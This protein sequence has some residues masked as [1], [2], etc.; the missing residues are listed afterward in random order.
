VTT[1]N[2]PTLSS[3]VD[4]E[5]RRAFLAIKA[6]ADNL[7]LQ[8]TTG[9]GTSAGATQTGITQ[10]SLLAGLGA[11]GSLTPFLDATVPPALVN[12]TATGA[13]RA[14]MLTW[15][16]PIFANSAYVEVWRATVNDVGASVLVGTAKATSGVYADVPSNSSLAIE[17]YY[18]C[19]IISIA[20]II[21][22]FNAVVAHSHTAN[23]PDYL[24]EVLA[25]GT[26]VP[27]IT[28]AVDTV[29][30]G[31]TVPAGTY[32][33]DAFIHDATIVTAHIKDAAIDSA[34]IA[35]LAVGSA[36][37]ADAAITNVKIGNLIQSTAYTPGSVGWSINKDGTAE[38]QNILARGDIEA[39]SLK[40]NTLMVNT[41]NI[42]DLAVDT[43]QLAG[44]AVTLPSSAYTEGSVSIG[45]GDVIVQTLMLTGDGSPV[46]VGVSFMIN[47]LYYG[48][49][50]CD[51]VLVKVLRGTTVI[52]QALLPYTPVYN[53]VI[54][55]CYT[56]G[57]FAASLK[58]VPAAG[59]V[60]YYVVMNGGGGKTTNGTVTN[61]YISTILLK[62]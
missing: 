29:I 39:L 58:D 16:A 50:T 25:G 18:W 4:G 36:K 44:Q 46:M 45:T 21:G 62:R 57:P 14:V 59:A 49:S 61:R 5:V 42:H 8:V 20:G 23:N 52:Y 28:L 6:W 13:F 41:G 24:L 38:F 10:E 53:G 60:T 27:L 31:V 3:Q 11:I 30:N 47:G 15:D 26:N 7:T 34:K 55:T 48:D 35:D 54:W 9:T 43:L 37:I 32:I 51:G 17:Y 22:P 19:R 33:R 2:I 12:V 40:A 56:R 1:P